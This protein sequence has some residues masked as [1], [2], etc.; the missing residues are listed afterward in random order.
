MISPY[1][2]FQANSYRDITDFCKDEN[3]SYD[4]FISAYT[5]EDIVQT[6]YKKI[7]ANKKIWLIFPEYTI[8]ENSIDGEKFITDKID[9]NTKEADYIS[10]MY[11]VYIAPDTKKRICIDSTG[12]NKPYL[13]FLIFLLKERGLQAVDILY[14]EPQSYPDGSKTKFSEDTISPRDIVAFNEYF[15]GRGESD[16]FIVNVGYDS[17]LVNRV[18]NDVRAKIKPLLG[19]PSLQPIM[20]QGNILNLIKSKSDLGIEE[21]EELLYAPA[22]HPFITAHV[23]SEYVKSYVTACD[24]DEVKNIY[25]APL[26]TKA[27]TIGMA[28]FYIFEKEKYNSMDISLHIRYP[29]TNKYSASSSQGYFRINQYT[30]EFDLFDKVREVNDFTN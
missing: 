26:A 1:H 11:N 2:L 6:T 25:L 13:I 29:F 12:F 23:I 15:S 8:D 30:V 27:Q 28:L 4:I 20:Y 22:N 17:R 10:E 16:L 14:T 7:H 18:I 19:F 9:E 5:N 21:N 24:A 3:N